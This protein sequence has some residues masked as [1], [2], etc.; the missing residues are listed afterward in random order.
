[1]VRISEQ[2][3]HCGSCSTWT[4]ANIIGLSNNCENAASRSVQKSML[5]QQA[6]AITEAP[7]ANS[8]MVNFEAVFGLT[9]A[10]LSTLLVPLRLETWDLFL[11]LFFPRRFFSCWLRALF[12]FWVLQFAD[13]NS[14]GYFIAI[15]TLVRVTL[16]W[17][18]TLN[19]CSFCATAQM[20]LASDMLYLNIFLQA[21][22]VSKMQ[23]ISNSFVV[24]SHSDD[25]KRKYSL[26]VFG[27]HL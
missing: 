25:S 6:D 3:S 20:T 19:G 24:I 27:F 18:S 21:K 15:F 10:T 9:N 8:L 22:N 17:C 23:N 5:L 13:W 16:S 7:D 11:E 12:F 14:C 26:T 2:F 4:Y 1:M